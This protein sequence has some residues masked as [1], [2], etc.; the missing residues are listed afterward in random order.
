MSR[1]IDADKLIEEI[2]ERI[3][4]AIE[5]GKSAETE[6]IKIRAEQSIATFCEASLT[7]KKLSTADVVEVVRC[8]DCKH[9]KTNIPCVGGHYN[10]CIEWLNEGCAAEVNEDDFCS[11]GE[12]HE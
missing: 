4:A 11:Y 3:K 6:E 2:K 10:G 9:Y 12:K 1:Y 8:K 7:A 5:W